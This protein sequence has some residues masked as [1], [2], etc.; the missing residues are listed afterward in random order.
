MDSVVCSV[1][2]PEGMDSVVCSVA[3]PEGMDS[4]VCSVA[5]PEGMDSVVCSVAGPE[6]MDSVVCSVA[7]PEGRGS[8]D[9]MHSG[10]S[11]GKGA[12]SVGW[13]QE[14]KISKRESTGQKEGWTQRRMVR[15]NC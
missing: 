6:G 12:I 8:A 3:G 14:R 4:V 1:A 2:G 10:R 7:G 13:R 5:G 9:Y 15:L 11:K